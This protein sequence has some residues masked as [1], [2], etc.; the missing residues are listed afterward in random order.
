M[1]KVVYDKK[2][3]NEVVLDA[4]DLCPV[5]GRWLIPSKCTETPPP[6]RKQGFA[7]KFVGGEWRQVEILDEEETDLFRTESASVKSVREEIEELKARLDFLTAE[8]AKSEKR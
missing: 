2:T 3:G 8:L 7:L 6:E 1:K 4:S 5:S